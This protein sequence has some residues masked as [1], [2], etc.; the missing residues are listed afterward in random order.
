M[1]SLSAGCLYIDVRFFLVR[2]A[3]TAPS[4]SHQSPLFGRESSLHSVTVCHLE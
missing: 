1:G 4:S 3:R 2:A